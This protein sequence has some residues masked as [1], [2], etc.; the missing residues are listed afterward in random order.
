VPGKHKGEI[1]DVLYSLPILFK[2]KK[3]L[4]YL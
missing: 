2:I 1:V 4:E 3:W